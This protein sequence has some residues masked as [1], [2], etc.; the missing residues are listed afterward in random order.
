MKQ[1]IRNVAT[2]FLTIASLASFAGAAP[3][4]EEI[5]EKLHTDYLVKA[6]KALKEDKLEDAL[7]LL[8][9][10]QVIARSCAESSERLLPEKQ[11]PESRIS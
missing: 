11:A 9:A 8:R 1:A 4:N 3:P 7:R 6:Q 10:A 2:S 5:C